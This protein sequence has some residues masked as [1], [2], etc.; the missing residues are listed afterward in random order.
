MKDSDRSPA[1]VCASEM[2]KSR[3]PRLVSTRRRPGYG[4]KLSHGVSRL[5]VACVALVVS[6]V[7]CSETT[8]ADRPALD[9]HG[10]DGDGSGVA[11]SSTTP[12][13]NLGLGFSAATL[14]VFRFTNSP[15]RLDGS[16]D[17][18]ERVVLCN[19]RYIEIS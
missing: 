6:A 7:A 11:R 14:G 1:R 18:S 10:K 12:E 3:R 19:Q 5:L 8:P 4:R 2:P 17:S 15:Q 13:P 9:G 16:F